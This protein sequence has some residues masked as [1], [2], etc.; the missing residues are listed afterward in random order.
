[1]HRPPYSVVFAALIVFAAAS[2]ALGQP[3][4]KARPFQEFDDAPAA[5][6]AQKA[7]GAKAEAPVPAQANKTQGSSALTPTQPAAVKPVA[8]GSSNPQ[9]APRVAARATFPGE[10][11]TIRQVA[12][13]LRGI[14]TA[15]TP[16]KEDLDKALVA[17]TSPPDS[18]SGRP[19]PP[20]KQ[21][22]QWELR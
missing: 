21:S 19:G 5:A 4:G 13:S 7:P 8:K 18:P 6:V 17:V 16:S 2:V 3:N 9:R 10:G 1:M 20:W 11:K 15:L 22:S 14:I 12:E